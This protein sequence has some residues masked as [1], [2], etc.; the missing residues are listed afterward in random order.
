MPVHGIH[1]VLRV[2]NTVFDIGKLRNQRREHSRT[3]HVVQRV[4]RA[5]RSLQHLFKAFHNVGICTERIIHP[6]QKIPHQ[7][8]GVLV[9][10]KSQAGLGLEK[11]HQQPGFG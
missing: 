3:Q 7:A 8:Q 10:G 4:Y 1:V 5:G 11:R 6:G 9:Q 2:L